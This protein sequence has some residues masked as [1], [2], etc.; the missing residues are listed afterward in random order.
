MV[1]CL[2]RIRGNHDGQKGELKIE[3]ER[4]KGEREKGEREE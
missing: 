3:R 2:G 1:E 4:E